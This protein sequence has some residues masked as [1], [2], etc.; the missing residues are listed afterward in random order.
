MRN[1]T[2]AVSFISIM[3]LHAQP[4][5]SIKEIPVFPHATY[6][7]E[8]SKTIREGASFAVKNEFEGMSVV[9]F[10]TRAY[11]VNASQ[12]EVISYYKKK[13]NAVDVREGVRLPRYADIRPNSST[14][15]FLEYAVVWTSFFWDRKDDRG[16]IFHFLVTVSDSIGFRG[17]KGRTILGLS[18]K[19][20]SKSVAKYVPTEQDLGAPVYQNARYVPEESSRSAYMGNHTFISDDDIGTVVAF[21]EKELQKKAVLAENCPGGK[22]FGFMHFSE[23]HEDNAITIE[24][25]EQQGKK[26]VRIYYICLMD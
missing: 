25:I 19:H 10:E 5:A 17:A 6:L 9:G 11:S 16:D 14:K 26:R 4:S 22:K 7:E 3:S 23:K 13:L 15:V 12:D 8:A 1:H 18:F 20:Y 21:F 2:L 24:Q